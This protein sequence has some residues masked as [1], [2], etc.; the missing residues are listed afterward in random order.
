MSDV[1]DLDSQD[2]DEAGMSS[3]SLV[4]SDVKTPVTS[5]V[6]TPSPSLKANKIEKP[7]KKKGQMTFADFKSI[8]VV[9]SPSDLS[10]FATGLRRS[11]RV[12]SLRKNLNEEDLID[13]MKTKPR[14][15]EKDSTNDTNK[16]VKKLKTSSSLDN[17]NLENL[18]L[19]QNWSPN[20]PI[21]SSDFIDK[22]S[23]KGLRIQDIFAD[24]KNIPYAGTIMKLMTFLNKFS[25]FFSKDLSKLSFQ[26]FEIGL[27][28]YPATSATKKTSSLDDP[29]KAYSDFIP[30]K[31]II[32]SQDKIN[33]FLLTLLKLLFNIPKSGIF[34]SP[35]LE[36]FRSSKTKF[37]NLFQQLRHKAIEWG[38]PKEWR[39][40]PIAISKWEWDIFEKIDNGSPV[41]PKNPE[42]LTNRLPEVPLMQPLPRESDPLYASNIDKKGILALNP[43]DRVT[44]LSVLVDWCLINSSVIHNEIQRLSHLKK[45]F[46][47]GIV[48]DHAP[49]FIANGIAQ[50][51]EDFH[52]LTSLMHRKLLNR[53]KK[54]SQLREDKRKDL[55]NKLN[56]V[57]EITKS[58]KGVKY[59]QG[60]ITVADHSSKWSKLFIDEM[61]DT[62]VSYPYEDVYKLR[63]QE[64]LV[65]RI[66]NCGDF[67]LPR[68]NTYGDSMDVFWFTDAPTLM[69]LLEDLS[70]NKIDKLNFYEQFGHLINIEFKLLFH[71]KRSMM[72]DILNAKT[73]EDSQYW[74]EISTDIESLDKFLSN[75]KELLATDKLIEQKSVRDQC[76][77]L[78]EYLAYFRELIHMLSN[79]KDEFQE[80]VSSS[81][82]S[83][84]T[85]EHEINYAVDNQY[86][87]DYE[88]D[89]NEEYVD[90]ND[91]S[92]EE[93]MEEGFSDNNYQEEEKSPADEEETKSET[94]SQSRRD[95]SLRR[96]AQR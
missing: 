31:D 91:Y 67:Y 19:N 59:K 58:L 77:A 68:L 76:T 63:M 53:N 16:M 20:V 66:S 82:R 54:R 27:D 14:R 24:V 83:R 94:E 60:L 49:R 5:K 38:Y 89:V 1:I 22:D 12:P 78:V 57:N 65:G 95:R 42:I 48:T 37:S 9:H 62:P 96:A 79:M 51:Y 11:A 69:R 71:D 36:Q 61:M 33:L 29:I 21:L 32:D 7:P 47:F 17:K 52:A 2:T 56:L 85:Q 64:F 34:Q 72:K 46:P 28:L 45:D 25:S 43:S 73:S 39:V 50:T 41:D 3:D 92:E 93:Y 15:K 18:S 4:T 87:D 70:S 30:T 75:I 8:K 23:T 84:R 88:D 86:T 26:T 81:R 74:F 40:H 10:S 80:I 55:S 35:E 44:L 6:S 90:A 13:E